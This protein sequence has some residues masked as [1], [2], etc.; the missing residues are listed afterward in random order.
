M[1]HFESLLWEQHPRKTARARARRR[2][3]K[4]SEIDDHSEWTALPLGRLGKP[5]LKE[6][7]LYLEFFA[8]A[9]AEPGVV[10]VAPVVELQ[11]SFGMKLI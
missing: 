1:A 6:I 10:A 7:A 3:T 5:L 4:Q 8:L 2:V 9:H 11:R